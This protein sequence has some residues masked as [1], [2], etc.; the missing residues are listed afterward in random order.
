MQKPNLIDK[1]I[2]SEIDKMAK[3]EGEVILPEPKPIVSDVKIFTVNLDNI[4][5]F[6][7]TRETK[8]VTE[9]KNDEA[10]TDTNRGSVRGRKTAVSDGRGKRKYYDTIY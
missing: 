1:D 2:E 3:E 4:I 6:E 5:K 7:R 10:E 8:K 9:E